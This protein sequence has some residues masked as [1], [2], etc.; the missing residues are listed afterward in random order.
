MS[1][2]TP[3]QFWVDRHR[4][5]V[6]QRWFHFLRR[7][8]RGS[9]KDSIE[10]GSLQ[11][12]LYCNST[13]L[14]RANPQQDDILLNMRKKADCQSVNWGLLRKCV[15]HL[16]DTNQQKS[17]S[18]KYRTKP[19]FMAVT[20]FISKIKWRRWPNL[21][22]FHRIGFF[23]GAMVGQFRVLAFYVEIWIAH[24]NKSAWVS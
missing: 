13:E 15:M 8:R 12:G 16:L 10:I 9:W 4:W 3:N 20:S 7:G 21:W 24:S 14:R 2:R 22:L 11:T 23:R 1:W 19:I 6:I 18:H 5:C 17:W